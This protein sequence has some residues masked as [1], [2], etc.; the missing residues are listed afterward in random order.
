[1]MVRY[2]GMDV[3]REFAQLAVVEDGLVRDEGRIGVTSEALRQW[4]AGLRADDQVALEATGNSDAIATLLTPVVGRVVV[5]NPSKTRAIAEAKVKTDK[6]DARILA[7]LLAADFLPPVWLPD[8][9]I[10]SLR[11]QVTRRA[12][13]VRQRT[14][15]KNQ[16]HAILARN[17]VP[18]PPVSDL[19]GK[20][21]RHWLS[22]Q[23]LP[24]DESSSVRA[25]LRQ[26]DF[27]GE[28]LAVVD[29]ELAVEAFADPAVAR[30]MTIPGVD[31]IVA[32][33]IVAAV[34][35]FTRFRDADKLVAYVGLNP[36]V[37]QS[38]NS[39]PVHGRIS[40]AGRAHV[41]GVLVEA[42]WSASRA[43]GPLRAF[44]QR[45]KARRGF[46]TAVVATARKMTALAWHLVTKDQDYAFAR[47]G[48]VAHKRR[49]LELATGAPS[50]RGNHGTPGAAY[51]DKQRRA[52]ETAAV[53][54]AERA[55]E[56]F[57]AHWQPHNPAKTRAKT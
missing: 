23:P 38:G 14:R 2:I 50:R 4:A 1:M 31:A 25:L 27:H 11:R 30:L 44:F 24:A 7:Q 29:K 39:A 46:P 32:I 36:K 33:S 45:V 48:L 16:V 43:P 26:L 54:Q 37:R 40:K 22:R 15:I 28:E 19:F 20:T 34:G 12:H 17:L 6:V 55:Y 53:E 13:L 10:R 35:D 21:G 56:V 49:K 51:N 8:E 57:V 18:T 9:R 52:A 47:P 3:H 41:R 42:A 5:S